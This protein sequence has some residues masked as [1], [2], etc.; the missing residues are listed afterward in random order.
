VLY[1]AG[2]F[3]VALRHEWRVD[4][5]LKRAETLE[6]ARNENFEQKNPR[7][8]APQASVEFFNVGELN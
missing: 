2:R 1:N 8:L 7:C 4:A 3:P 5:S 6:P